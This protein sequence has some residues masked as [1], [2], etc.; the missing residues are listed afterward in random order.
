[1]Q[2]GDNTQIPT[3]EMPP[4]ENQE[5]NKQER[6]L[7]PEEDFKKYFEENKEDVPP[8]RGESPE[9]IADNAGEFD[10]GMNDAARLLSYINGAPLG[11]ESLDAVADVV[12]GIDGSSENP[13]GEL[14]AKL[15]FKEGDSESAKAQHDR[16]MTSD[17]ATN[18][19]ASGAIDYAEKTSAD[20]RAAFNSALSSFKEWISE[21]RGSD[22]KYAWAREKAMSAGVGV[23]DYLKQ[24]TGAKGLAD[25]FQILSTHTEEVEETNEAV[26]EEEEE[27]EENPN[28]EE[29]F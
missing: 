13:F 3:W 14:R 26:K 1:M 21:V 16:L 11:N 15:G 4:G 9:T 27:K 19:N 17:F 5:M 2:Q 23:F 22:P 7:S 25:V 10:E 6:D 29:N 20:S 28:F 24:Y 8:F 18:E 12:L